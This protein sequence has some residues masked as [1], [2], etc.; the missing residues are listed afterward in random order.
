MC[1]RNGTDGCTS[2]A[3]QPGL[4]S[5]YLLLYAHDVIPVSPL[6]YH[7]SY[8]SLAAL[9]IVSLLTSP[10][11]LLAFHIISPSLSFIAFFFFFFLSDILPAMSRNVKSK[12]PLLPIYLLSAE[13]SQSH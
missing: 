5:R 12:S 7:F 6:V 1:P 13:L 10:T 3:L 9:P 2:S 11:C 8:Y 4:P